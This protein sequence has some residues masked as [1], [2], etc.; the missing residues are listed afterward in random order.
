MAKVSN[1]GTRI[2]VDEHDLS[3]FLNAAEQ[4]VKQATPD[5]GCFSDVGPRRIVDGYDHSHSHNGFLDPAD[6]SFDERAFVDLQTDE[7]HYL[8]HLWGAY[9]EGGIVYESI[10]RLSEQMRAGKLGSAQLLNLAAQGSGGMSR[11]VILRNAT[12]TADGNGTGR[13]VGATTLGQITQVTF[14][15]FSGVFTHIDVHIESST[16]DGAGDA[17][18]DVAGLV[19]E[20]AAADTPGVVRVTTTAATEAWKRVVISNWAGTS[21][22]VAVTCGVVAGS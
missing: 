19:A 12:V 9:A 2:W 8:A 10:V 4:D 21:A 22:V 15:V 11:A 20:F 13:N 6:N 7:D 1:V 3:G 5:V 17:Y 16:D 18:A 14:R